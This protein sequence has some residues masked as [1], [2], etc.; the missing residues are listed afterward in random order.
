MNSHPASAVPSDE[1]KAYID[2]INTAALDG[3]FDAARLCLA[4]LREKLEQPRLGILREASDHLMRVLGPAGA[5]P[6]AGL[7]RALVGLTDALAGV[8]PR[9]E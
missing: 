7:G 9:T 1:F 3:D 2:A 5:R 6:S 4:Q 8:R